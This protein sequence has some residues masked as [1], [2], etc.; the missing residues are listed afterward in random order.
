MQA[1]LPTFNANHEGGV[2]LVTSSVAGIGASGSSMPYSVTKA[3]GLSTREVRHQ[4]S[5]DDSPRITSCEVSRGHS[6]SEG[7]CQCNTPRAAED[8][9]G[10]CVG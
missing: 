3:S 8:R 10:E 7:P 1:A 9:M 5:I 6:G 4:I 2:F